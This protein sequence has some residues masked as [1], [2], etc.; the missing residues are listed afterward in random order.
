[1]QGENKVQGSRKHVR[2]SQKTFKSPQ[3]LE[4]PFMLI[5]AS[6]EESETLWRHNTLMQ[7]SHYKVGVQCWRKR[8]SGPADNISREHASKDT[9]ER[10]T[11]Q[12]APG[13]NILQTENSHGALHF[14]PVFWR[15]GPF[16]EHLV[17]FSVR[18]VKAL[19]VFK[20]LHSCCHDNQS[21][22]WCK[23]GII[24]VKCHSCAH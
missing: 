9:N 1:M 18:F 11:V 7:F 13:N 4:R 14:R 23:L 3:T 24:N 8:Q 2:F 16:E 21:E 10:G 15:R 19:G 6:S 12:E 22:Q 5:H 17:G 20:P